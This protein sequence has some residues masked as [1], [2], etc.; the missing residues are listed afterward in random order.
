MEAT[1]IHDEAMAARAHVRGILK[2]K[3]SYP[4]TCIAC[5]VRLV[6]QTSIEIEFPRYA[7]TV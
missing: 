3:D 7:L 6:L 4:T 2:G 1:L 5:S